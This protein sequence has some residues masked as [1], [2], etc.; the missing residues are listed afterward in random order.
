[1]QAQFSA[2]MATRYIFDGSSE[3][4][5]DFTKYHNLDGIH[6]FLNYIRSEHK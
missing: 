6:E 3:Y 1:M 4:K 5:P 2:E